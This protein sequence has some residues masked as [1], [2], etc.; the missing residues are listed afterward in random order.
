MEYLLLHLLRQPVNLAKRKCPPSCIKIIVPR[1]RI[2]INNVTMC[3][4]YKIPTNKM[5]AKATKI[6]LSNLSSIPPC[7]GIN[8]E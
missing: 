2:N 8:D 6:K 4:S 5:N 3:P 1:I 7:P